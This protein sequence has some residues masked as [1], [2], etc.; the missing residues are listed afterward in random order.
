MS[1]SYP[2]IQVWPKPWEWTSSCSISVLSQHKANC[3]SKKHA[4]FWCVYPCAG[5]NHYFHFSPDEFQ[6]SVS[7]PE[8]EY[9]GTL[10]FSN[11][12]WSRCMIKQF[13]RV[14]TPWYLCECSHL[15]S[16]PS[17]LNQ[18]YT[19]SYLCKTSNLYWISTFF[20]E[21]DVHKMAVIGRCRLVNIVYM[22]CPFWLVI[23]CLLYMPC[24]MS[25]L[26]IS[27]QSCN[28]DFSSQLDVF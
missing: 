14:A 9:L 25:T 28:S 6:G 11:I 13:S 16:F 20:C 3:M 7:I 12:F 10:F 8:V 15:S 22:L 21:N 27:L 5:W 19:V 18:L 23:N 17:V 1:I 2:H 24:V 26:R 4:W